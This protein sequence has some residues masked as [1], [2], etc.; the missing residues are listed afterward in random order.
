[1]PAAGKADLFKKIAVHVLTQEGYFPK[2]LVEQ[3]LAF[4]YDGAGIAAAF[5]TAGEGHHAKGTHVIA[6]THDAY[7]GIDPVGI[8]PDGRDVGIGFFP[9]QQHVDG[10]LPVSASRINP[11]RLR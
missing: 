1:M 11:G 3:I 6:A 9:A 5:A 10:L 4:L 2:A 7:K 8:E